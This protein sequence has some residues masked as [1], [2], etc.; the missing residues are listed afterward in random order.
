[1]THNTR[2]R[3]GLALDIGNTKTHGQVRNTKHE[4]LDEWTVSTS[5][6]NS[7][8]EV[9]EQGYERAQKSLGA[10]PEFVGLGFGGPV[11]PKTGAAKLTLVTAFNDTVT[12]E[13]V[14]TMLG[15]VPVIHLNDV[16]ASAHALDFP[17][18]KIDSTLLTEEARFE[19]GPSVLVEI[20]T[21]V[22]TAYCLPGGT[23]MPSE[24][25]RIHASNGQPYGL[26]LCGS[27]GFI[28][29]TR[30][31]RGNNVKMPVDIATALRSGDTLGPTITKQIAEEDPSEFIKRFRALYAQYLGEL[32]G[33]VQLAFL[34]TQI[35]IGGSVGRAP[36]FLERLL[37]TEEFWQAFAKKDA[38]R[39]KDM[40]ILRVNDTD[41]TVRGAYAAAIKHAKP[42]S[43]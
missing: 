41:A 4:L 36:M 26:N 12:S 6:H 11:D 27:Q 5:Q 20:G 18:F 1:M 13:G 16:A 29:L 17:H 37:A 9:I 33:T 42:S 23:V 7:L 3:G 28:N 38:L 19:I 32:L 31:L 40:P 25:V 22:G 30:E 34:A 10:K 21:G 39:G 14:S 15:G 8:A 24:A 2:S 43:H 35:F